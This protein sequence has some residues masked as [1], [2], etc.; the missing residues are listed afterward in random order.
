M[1]DAAATTS[2]SPALDLSSGVIDSSRGPLAPLGSLRWRGPAAPRRFATV[3]RFLAGA[4]RPARV[5]PLAGPRRP[6]PLR[7]RYSIP[8]GGP[9][10]PLGSLR[11]RGPAAP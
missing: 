7:D 11:W 10:A 2:S 3:T 9:L 4:P 8:R 5:P 1:A 6:A